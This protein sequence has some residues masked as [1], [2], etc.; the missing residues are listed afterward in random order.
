[1]L[2]PIT[3]YAVVD[4]KKPKLD[5]NLI[6]GEKDIILDENEEIIKIIITP[7]LKTKKTKSKR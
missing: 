1:M 6:F 4:N 3:A 5:I 2:K 7:C